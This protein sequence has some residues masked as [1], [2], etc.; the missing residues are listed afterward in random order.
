MATVPVRT[1]EIGEQNMIIVGWRVVLRVRL[2]GSCCEH[3]ARVLHGL[4][5]RESQRC[6][7]MRML[8]FNE[9]V[10]GCGP[11]V[12]VRMVGVGMRWW[13]KTIA[14]RRGLKLARRL[15]VIYYF[16]LSGLRGWAQF[17]G[18]HIW[19]QTTGLRLDC[20]RCDDTRRQTQRAD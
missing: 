9:E 19:L 4:V 1:V 15:A 5:R 12:G 18:I 20:P 8:T 14:S 11:V 10:P 16:G 6:H 13:R 3:G 7:V 2:R 17:K